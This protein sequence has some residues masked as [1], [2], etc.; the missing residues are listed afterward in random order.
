MAAGA[1]E[2]YQGIQ[3]NLGNEDSRHRLVGT[4]SDPIGISVIELVAHPFESQ[5]KIGSHSL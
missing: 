5:S 1:V 4:M 3:E 2:P